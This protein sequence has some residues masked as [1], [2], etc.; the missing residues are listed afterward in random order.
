MGHGVQMWLQTMW[1]LIRSKGTETVV[2]D[3][4]DVYMHADLQ[5]KLIRYIRARFTQVIVTTH[6]S[7]IMESRH[8]D[9]LPAVQAVLANLGSAQNVHLARLATATPCGGLGAR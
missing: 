6:S 7:E 8:A 2:L 5:R 9:N 3:E 1:F 4:P